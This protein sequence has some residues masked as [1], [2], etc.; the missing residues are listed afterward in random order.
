MNFAF[1]IFEEKGSDRA[2]GKFFAQEILPTQT[3]N[4]PKKKKATKNTSFSLENS[5]PHENT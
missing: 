4:K 1:D 5:M 3:K 2:L